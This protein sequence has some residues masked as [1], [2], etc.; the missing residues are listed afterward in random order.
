MLT[1]TYSLVAMS[2]EHASVRA[3][4]NAFHTLI[5][6]T[7]APEPSLS[8]GQVDFA[9]LAMQRLY[10]AF[11]HRKVE[12][13]LI[14]AVRKLTH[15]AD[16]LLAELD[17]L[18][19][20]AAQAMNWLFARARDGAIEGKSAVASF[21]DT[22]DKFCSSLLTRLEREE[23]ELFPVARTALPVETWFDIAH[24][25]IAAES[26]SGK[27]RATLRTRPRGSITPVPPPMRVD[28]NLVRGMAS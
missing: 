16:R 24:Q 20:T 19:R 1:A 7:F 10:D 12:L 15:V 23:R 25:L 14:P 4:L 8:S 13:V 3:S 18:R 2:V 26:R 22:A 27:P 6:S 9:C 28:N 11:D 5:R 17:Q 21:C